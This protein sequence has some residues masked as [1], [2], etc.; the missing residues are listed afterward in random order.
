MLAIE[1]FLL[2]NLATNASI[3]I[4]V[5]VMSGL[6]IEDKI[7]P[8]YNETYAFGKF[9]PI[10][11]WKNTKRNVTISFTINATVDLTGYLKKFALL[12]LPKYST[13]GDSTYVTNAPIYKLN[14]F[15]YLEEFGIVKN[16]SVV[17]NYKPKKLFFAVSQEALNSTAAG[18]PIVETT[19][20]TV[21]GR[22]VRTNKY[23]I[24]E[25]G[26]SFDFTVLHKVSP[27]TAISGSLSNWPF[28]GAT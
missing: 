11:N 24:T 26:V 28:K 3:E 4:P 7:T 20:S 14:S 9:D 12:T 16:L 17:P 27:N 19:T 23:S 10:V 8:E 2:T 15:G 21:N 22:T 6:K 18:N 1:N 13:G 5:Y 25:I